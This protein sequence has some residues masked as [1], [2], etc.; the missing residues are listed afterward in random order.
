MLRAGR[1]PSELAAGTVIRELYDL[2]ADPGEHHSLL[3]GVGG[4]P[5]W[6][7]AWHALPG[8]G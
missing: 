3:S 6:R 8:G 1:D 7:S 5:A 4:P 2:R